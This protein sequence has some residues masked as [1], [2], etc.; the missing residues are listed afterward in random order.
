MENRILLLIR[1]SLSHPL[2]SVQR[3]LD[4]QKSLEEYVNVNMR[5]TDE[6]EFIMHKYQRL[7]DINAEYGVRMAQF[8]KKFQTQ[9]DEVNVKVKDYDSKIDDTNKRV[10]HNT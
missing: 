9:I 6:H 2:L 8:D 4:K 5:R 1:D 7:A 3:S 10:K